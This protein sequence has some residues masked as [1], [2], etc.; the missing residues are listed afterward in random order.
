MTRTIVH[1][2]AA[3]LLTFLDTTQ[4]SFACRIAGR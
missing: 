3:M 1:G 2:A 4:V